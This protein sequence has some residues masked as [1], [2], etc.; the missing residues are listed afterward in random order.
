M[1]G[2]LA[3]VLEA[4][5]V[6]GQSPVVASFGHN[7][8]LLCTNLQPGT[9]ASVE[10]APA[11]VGPWTNT[12]AGL[13]AVVA[14]TNGAIR[15]SVPM[16][17]RV[18]GVPATPSI[19][20]FRITEDYLRMRDGVRL[21]VTHY[22]PNA[23][24]ARTFPVILE[25]TPYRKDDDSYIYAY[26]VYNYFARR[27][28]AVAHVDVRGT[29]S[30]EGTLPDREYSDAE[31]DDLEDV[32]AAL[33]R[34]PWSNGSIGM[35]GISWS[36]FNAIMT[37]MRRPPA[38][39]AIL[40]AHASNDLYGNDVNYIDGGLHL[41][42]FALEMEVE[43]IVPR[44]PDYAINAAYFN[45]R[46]KQYPWVLTYLHQQRDGAFWQQ[47]RSL[48]S[49][50][51]AVD[52]PVYAIG[53]LLDGYR[54]FVPQLLD[55]L[56]VPIHAEIG[57]WNHAWP[58][59]GAP[60]PVYEWRKTAIRWW[61]R[62]LGGQPA[63]AFEESSLTVFQRSAIPPDLNMETTPGY[64]R[65]ESWPVKGLKG[66]K[67]YLETDKRL[68]ET[69]STGLHL[70]T[71]RYKPSNGIAVGN[72]WGEVTGEMSSSD[73][74]AL[75][76]DSQPVAAATLIL[77]NSQVQLTVSADAPLADWV[78]R[79]EDVFPD[80]RVSLVTGGLINGAQRLSRTQPQ[81][82]VPGEVFTLHVP[83]RFTSYTFEPQHKI[84]VVVSN[85]QFPMIWPTPHRMTTTLLAGG[86]SSYIELPIVP[87]GTPVTLPGDID[88]YEEPADA[89]SLSSEPLTYFKIV[90]DD[91]RGITEVQSEEGASFMVKE[92]S[93]ER[94][95]NLSYWVDNTNPAA[96]GF[97]GEGWQKTIVDGRELLMRA[98]IDITSTRDSFHAIVNRSIHENGRLLRQKTWDEVIPRDFQ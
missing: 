96:A 17:Y 39:K 64:F 5:P 16:F 73:R 40:V 24:G 72:W 88:P 59:D 21:A 32:V 87:S 52:I 7:G 61:E 78:V 74:D 42:V 8:D 2:T 97:R 83:L 49:N 1:L 30:S 15:V 14:D 31:L 82:I 50:W 90:R 18:R 55:H 38:L 53:G 13:A 22:V 3:L 20:D 68:S 86:G 4:V 62:W 47:G 95:N 6:L 34:L 56:A 69:A 35:Q 92:R 45:D 28:I 67:F 71:L 89:K 27:G 9:E 11:V 37:A 36:G 77:G 63:G 65:L 46:F 29:G 75:V 93:F 85:A 84:R 51:G 57:P 81:A 98:H 12:W 44:S 66:Q 58:H 54:D 60:G 48:Q 41:D 76:F 25:M 23:P 80:G 70:Q 19:S 33:A 43:N 94:K 10:W 26:S 79:L 91:P